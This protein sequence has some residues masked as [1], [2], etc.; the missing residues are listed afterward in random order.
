MHCRFASARGF[1]PNTHHITV[2]GGIKWYYSADYLRYV[3]SRAVGERV[4]PSSPSPTTARLIHSNRISTRS[5]FCNT[6]IAPC[7]SACTA[8]CT[9]PRWTSTRTGIRAHAQANSASRSGSIRS[10]TPASS[11]KQS[12]S[13]GVAVSNHTSMEGSASARRPAVATSFES[14]SRTMGSSLMMNTVLSAMEV[15]DL[16]WRGK[17]KERKGSSACPHDG[18]L[19]QRS[20]S[21][22]LL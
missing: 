18:R 11:T 17:G 15:S 1:R 19:E 4:A 22:R 16:P 14:E 10:P 5:G 3:R 8:V 9:A 6:S 7:L 13:S 12:G 21:R 20:P 2:V